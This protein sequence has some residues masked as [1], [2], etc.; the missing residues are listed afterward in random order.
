MSFSAPVRML[1]ANSDQCS[2]TRETQPRLCIY[3]H[4]Q[5]NG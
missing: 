2:N 1:L 3:K 5:L 4:I